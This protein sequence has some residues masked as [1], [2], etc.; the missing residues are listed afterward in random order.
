VEPLCG[1]SKNREKEG[2]KTS[3][4]EKKSLGK[5]CQEQKGR[6]DGRGGEGKQLRKA[7]G[8]IQ[9]IAYGGEVMSARE[10]TEHAQWKGKRGGRR[11]ASYVASG[12]ELSHKLRGETP[13]LWG[14]PLEIME[15]F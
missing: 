14:W 8:C 3:W 2:K 4:R 6:H 15:V 9:E 13:L 10:R 1:S 5:E 7:F 11:Q 12:E